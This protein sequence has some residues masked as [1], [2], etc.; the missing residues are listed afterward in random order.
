MYLRVNI[1]AVND[2]ALVPVIRRISTR[3]LREFGADEQTQDRMMTVVTEACSNVV[4]YAFDGTGMYEVGLEYSEESVKLSVRDYGKG[5]D[6]K[7]VPEPDV[8]RVGGRG[9]A[10][11]REASSS[12]TVE[13]APGKG[14]L[15]TAEVPVA[16]RNERFRLLVAGMPSL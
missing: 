2:A 1:K 7:A 4:K 8:L 16:Y 5:F 15:V 14:T 11:I 10:F 12:A 3:V 6:P 13:S 9:I